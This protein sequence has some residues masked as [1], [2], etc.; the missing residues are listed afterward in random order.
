VLPGFDVLAGRFSDQHFHAS[1]FFDQKGDR[2]WLVFVCNRV[3]L[4]RFGFI[5][6]RR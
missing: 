4:L 3:L 6:W 5:L 1:C 2:W